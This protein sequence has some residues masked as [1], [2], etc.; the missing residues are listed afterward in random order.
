MNWA[1]EQRLVADA[2]ARHVLLCLANYADKVGRNAFPSAASLAEDTGLSE[3][4]VRY[5]LDDLERIG[6][7]KRGNQAIARAH[8]DRRDRTPVCYDLLMQRGA[9][10][11]PR[12]GD[13][14]EARTGCS[15]CTSSEC[16]GCKPQQ[17]GVQTATERGAA[18]APNPSFNHQVTEEQQHAP[19]DAWQRYPM[20]EDWQPD[21]EALAAQ[22]RVAQLRAD[23]VTTEIYQ[24]FVAHFL[25]APN[26]V[27]TSAGWCKRLAK[28]TKREFAN[29]AGGAREQ[30]KTGVSRPSAGIPLA[31][32]LNG[33]GW[34]PAAAL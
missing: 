4:T 13:A 22:L 26:V 17:N 24:A 11:A 30:S 8:I 15:V 14:P 31:D 9:E 20:F 12:A 3:R 28:W 6:A 18:A 1:L 23:A 33:T 32:N 25:A 5:K 16:T 10:T 34:V 21:P 27:E 29:S 19:V 7:I 2:S